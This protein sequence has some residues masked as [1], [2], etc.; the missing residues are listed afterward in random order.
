MQNIESEQAKVPQEQ[1]S[2]EEI[3]EDFILGPI[4]KTFEYLM[5]FQGS[6]LEDSQS[7]DEY[8]IG[9]YNGLALGYAIVT[10]E[11]PKFYKEGNNNE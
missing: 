4:I 11:K 9:L 5:D 6:Y 3:P 8:N 1:Q 10:G 7:K 2:I